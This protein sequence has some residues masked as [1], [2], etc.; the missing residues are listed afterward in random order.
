M[1]V[2][3][4][5]PV[6]VSLASCY[7]AWGRARR[8]KKPSQ[9]QLAFE[10]HWLDN[11]QELHTTLR[12]GRWVSH[13][14]VSFIVNHPKTREI[15]APDFSDRIVHHL[16]VERLEKLYEPVFIHDSYANRSGRGSH[17]AV[18][19][20]QTLMCQRE[21]MPTHIGSGGWVL[22][23]DIHN[24]FNSI[25]RPTLY[26]ML[27]KQLAQ[28]QRRGQ[29]PAS[30]ATALQ[31]LCHK[32]LARPMQEH[33][34]NPLAALK[35]PQH[36]RLRHAAPGCG[37]PVGNLTSQFFANVYLNAL[38]QF[39]KHQLKVRHYVRYVDDFV[40]LGDSQ[41]QL[42]DWQ[43]QIND[44][45]RDTLRLKLRDD[46]YLQPIRRGVDFLG[47]VVF[48]HH[49]RVRTR[50]VEHC[51]EKLQAW[52]VSHEHR[53]LQPVHVAQLQALLG[54]YWGHFAHANSV[55]LRF[56]LFKQMPWLRHLFNLGVDARLYLKKPARW[57]MARHRA[58]RKFLKPEGE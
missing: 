49:R 40:L 11:L 14:T 48:A 10:G 27:C 52:Y 12:A 16:L 44:F 15:H 13:R 31:S 7:A 30:H 46:V 2:S 21:N 17:A 5:I 38:D 6:P 20:L 54:S 56:K 47:Y 57:Q 42:Q 4:D 34:R 8:G 18:D 28:A 19:R 9:N 43:A 51:L 45:L 36:K 41:Q 33:V 23:L 26:A 39:V 55:R 3:P 24:Y 29:L 35:M 37:L 22:Q 32:L 58:V 1:K 53:A 50:V 25:H